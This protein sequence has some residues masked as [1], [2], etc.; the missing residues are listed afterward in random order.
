M[1]NSF[2]VRNVVQSSTHLLMEFKPSQSA[3][4]SSCL[5]LFHAD[6]EQSTKVRLRFTKCTD[7]PKPNHVHH[8]IDVVNS[9][10]KVALA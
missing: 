1:R 5:Y 6:H 3:P 8:L 9:R 2:G 7:N 4:V 10:A